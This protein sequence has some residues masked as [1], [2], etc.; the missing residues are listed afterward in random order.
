MAQQ[1]NTRPRE[2][3]K[4][5]GPKT[6]EM[7]KRIINKKERT[8]GT[9]VPPPGETLKH[10]SKR[11]PQPGPG[12]A[13]RSPLGTDPYLEVRTTQANTTSAVPKNEGDFNVK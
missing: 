12:D 2:A 5:Q 9:D 13:Y 3:P 1:S 8:D 11:Y 7:Q 10:A 4:Q 6:K